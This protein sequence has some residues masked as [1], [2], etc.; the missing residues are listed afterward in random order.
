[1]TSLSAAFLP[2]SVPIFPVREHNGVPVRRANLHVRLPNLPRDVF[3]FGESHYSS[4]T[5]ANQSKVRQDRV[6]LKELRS[7]F[8]CAPTEPD[9]S[10]MMSLLRMAPP[11]MRTLEW[12]CAY[13]ESRCDHHDCVDK[14]AAYKEGN[15]PQTFGMKTFNPFEATALVRVKVR[16]YPTPPMEGTVNPSLTA[17]APCE[18][19]T[20]SCTSTGAGAGAHAEGWGCTG[21]CVN[22]DWREGTRGTERTH[23]SGTLIRAFLHPCPSVARSCRH[24]TQHYIDM[25]LNGSHLL[26]LKDHK[27]FYINEVLLLNLLRIV[28]LPDAVFL[29]G[30]ERS[31]FPWNIPFPATSY[32]PRIGT[33][34][35]PWPWAEMWR[36]ENNLHR[37]AVELNK[38]SDAVIFEFTGQKPWAQRIPKVLSDASERASVRA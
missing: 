19:R 3:D 31:F 28:R 36:P 26:K 21:E 30:G 10:P 29:M 15:Y 4:K 14:A 32:A 33:G 20:M 13:C 34:E 1:M 16:F 27:D 5:S 8:Q 2:A 38:F 11:T 12:V 24:R 6:T 9:L 7:A 35:V 22:V 17:N 37:K 23:A 18:R 25:G